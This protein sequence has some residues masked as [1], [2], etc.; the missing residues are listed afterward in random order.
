MPGTSAVYQ[1]DGARVA[2]CGMSDI[3]GTKSLVIGL[4]G[5]IGSGKSTIAKLFALHGAAMIDADQIARDLTVA[6]GQALPMIKAGFG[7][8]FISPDGALDRTLMR[9]HAF[10][11]PTLKARLEGILHPLIREEIF[12]KVTAEV[13]RGVPYIV[14]EIPLLFDAMSYR[15]ALSR[16][17]VVDCPVSMQIARVTL[18]STLS[19]ADVNAIIASQ[20]PRAI[21]LQLTDDVIENGGSEADLLASVARLNARYL[22]LAK[23]FP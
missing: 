23:L 8:Q 5:G 19:V 17:L 15:L 10:A 16:T 7:G 22:S 21:R 1:A 9:A 20:V 11:N 6:G 4:T 18:R 13:T 14:L 3:D 2:E 12:K